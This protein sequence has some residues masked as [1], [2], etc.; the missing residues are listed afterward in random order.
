VNVEI[1]A[2]RLNSF[3]PDGSKSDNKGDP[4]VHEVDQVW[5]HGIRRKSYQITNPLSW[6]SESDFPFFPGRNLVVWRVKA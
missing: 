1:F 3:F 5:S 2:I 6:F 4:Y